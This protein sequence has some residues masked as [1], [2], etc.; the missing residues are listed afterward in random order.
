MTIKYLLQAGLLVCLGGVVVINTIL[1]N[2][3]PGSPGSIL[4]GADR[5]GS[6]RTH[7]ETMFFLHNKKNIFIHDLF[8][9]NPTYIFISC[10]PKCFSDEN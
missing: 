8:F 6:L 9:E 5:A 1:G 4:Q 7:T 2:K 10:V 3:S